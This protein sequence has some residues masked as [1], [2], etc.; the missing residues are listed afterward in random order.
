M[1][2]LKC[3]FK[4]IDLAARTQH[5]T[6]LIHEIRINAANLK[7][8]GILKDDFTFA[9]HERS[10]KT[11]ESKKLIIARAARISAVVDII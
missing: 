3:V 6:E 4:Q 11:A 7:M 10:R 1:N 9:V 8:H 2:N 5:R